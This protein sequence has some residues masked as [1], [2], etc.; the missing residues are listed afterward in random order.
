MEKYETKGDRRRYSG[1]C[2]Y[3]KDFMCGILKGFL[4]E[5]FE[6]CHHPTWHRGMSQW[7]LSLHDVK[8]SLSPA[9]YHQYYSPSLPPSLTQPPNR[10]CIRK[11]CLLC[12]PLLAISL[13]SL[14]PG[15]L[16]LS[17]GTDPRPSLVRLVW[18]AAGGRGEACPL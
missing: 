16:K 10:K 6:S 11:I 12:V 14:L 4:L 18:G 5:S 13:A 7:H 17:V 15:S 1:F 8:P 2:V 9:L 3:L